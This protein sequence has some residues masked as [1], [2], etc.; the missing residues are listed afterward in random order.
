MTL[1][2][3]HLPYLKLRF[4][5]TTQGDQTA[6]IES[7][8][9]L[10][11]VRLFQ[12]TNATTPKNTKGLNTPQIKKD[13]MLEVEIGR[14][15][16]KN[17]LILAS[18]I[19]GVYSSSL[20]RIAEHAGAVVTK[21]VGMEEREGYRTPVIINTRLGL[22]NAVGLA[23][24]GSLAFSKELHKFSKDSKLIVSLFGSSPNEFS[25]LTKH[26]D[27]ADAFEL[28]LSCP[29]VEDAGITVGSDPK[30]VEKIVREVKRS[31]SKP[32]FVKVSSEYDYIE[33][34]KSAEKAGADGITAI[35]TL[36]GIAIDIR[37]R[38][39]ILSN[40]TGGVSGES[41]KPI[42]LKVVWDLYKEIDVPIIG[43]GGITSWKDVIEFMLAG[44]NAV[45]IGSAFFYSYRMLYSLK[46]S[47][48]AYLRKEKLEISD[49]VGLAHE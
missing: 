3:H 9:E 23:S 44:A 34:A 28:N 1:H 38:K 43:C 36:K 22:L 32:V 18:G 5:C 49:L 45:Q 20:N 35:N 41:I 8:K 29:H 13:W 27:M 47:L 39:P 16:M 4:V 15:K 17:P 6:K 7:T 14:M 25:E 46:E 33:T 2:N 12:P 40:T 48:I 21:S 26:F 42:S 31:T 24:P 19:L 30:L 11:K 10:T 37:T